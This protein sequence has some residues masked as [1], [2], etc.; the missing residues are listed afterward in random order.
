MFPQNKFSLLRLRAQLDFKR[1]KNVGILASV[2]AVKEKW[3][4]MH[5]FGGAE[6]E[7][8]VNVLDCNEFPARHRVAA[9]AAKM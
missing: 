7:G 1:G 9:H 2:A 3:E 6:A 5:Y 4:R 8:L